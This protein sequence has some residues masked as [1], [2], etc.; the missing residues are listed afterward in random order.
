MSK[1]TGWTSSTKADIKVHPEGHET[2]KCSTNYKNESIHNL[3]TLE[4]S[5]LTIKVGKEFQTGMMSMKKD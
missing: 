2:Q 1:H 4:E 5:L 3:K